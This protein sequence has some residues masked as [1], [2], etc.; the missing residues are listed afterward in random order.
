MKISSR[1]FL[2][3]VGITLTTLLGGDVRAAKI[4]HQAIVER[5]G[6]EVSGGSAQIVV[7]VKGAV[8]F[9][10]HTA[11]PDKARGLP[12]R[13]YVDL[14][15][16]R[17]GSAIARQ[18]IKVEDGLVERIRIGQFDK[19]TVRIVVDLRQPALF[20]VRTAANPPRLILS[21]RQ[22]PPKASGAR[23]SKAEQ[24][25]PS[26]PEASKSAEVVAT[27][28]FRVVLDPGH[29]GRD[30]GAVGVSGESE[31]KVTLRIAELLAQRLGADPQINVTLTRDSD[32]SVSLEDRAGIA[33]ARSAD[34]FISL[35]ANATADGL[36]RGIETYTL[37]NTDDQ[38]T[39]RLAALENGLALT[40]AKGKKGDLAFILSDMLQTGKAKESW[41]LAEAV[42]EETTSYLSSRW[43]SV[44]NLGVKKGPFYVLV[45][46]YMPCILVEV[47]FL[48]HPVEGQRLSTRRYQNDL[49]EG[50][51]RGI[52]R[53]LR[54]S[55][56][57]SSLENL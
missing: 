23:V 27:R 9:S 8:D 49:A 32:R 34:L 50:L 53:F 15:P 44:E 14:K 28:P 57:V 11:P 43:K 45:G 55:A 16:A 48:T 33:N 22:P 6:W 46:A 26:K 17:L 2:F 31:K 18:P 47:G 37:N 4:R 41:S 39:N 7:S 19:T 20:D 29:G 25:S 56:G 38:A 24:K 5:V 36:A 42:Q 3:W 51:A 21:L 52:K 13:A 12:P 30:P 10:S 1:S 40:G 54:S 35:H